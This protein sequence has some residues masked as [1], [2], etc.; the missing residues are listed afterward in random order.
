[1]TRTVARAV[2]KLHGAAHVLIALLRVDAQPHVD[3]D[4]LVEFRGGVTLDDR[5]RFPRR[6]IPLAIEG[7]GGCRGTSCRIDAS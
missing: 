2:G 3:L 4:R 7:L 5:A 1:M 6:T